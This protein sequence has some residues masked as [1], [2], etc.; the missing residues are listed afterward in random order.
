MTEPLFI[1][2]ME[3]KRDVSINTTAEIVVSLLKSVAARGFRRASGWN[4]QSS[5]EFGTLAALYQH[6]EY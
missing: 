6:N 3:R 5:T 1:S 2:A 4:L